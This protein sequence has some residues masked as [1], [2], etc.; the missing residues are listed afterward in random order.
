MALTPLLPTTTERGNNWARP[1]LLNAFRGAC[2]LRYH[3]HK[4]TKIFATAKRELLPI[5]RNLPYVNEVTAYSPPGVTRTSASAICF[6]IQTEAYQGEPRHL[7]WF[8]YLATQDGTTDKVLVKFTRQY[9]PEL[10][11]FCAERCHAPQLLGYNTIPGGWHVVV[12]EWIDHDDTNL[13]LYAPDHLP[14]WSKDLKSLVNGFHKEGWVHGD[15]RDANLIVSDEE[16]G[17]VML[18]DFDWGGNVGAGPVYY[19]TALVHEELKK[20]EHP[21]DLLI[22]QKHDA[23]VLT[24]TLNKLAG[25]ITQEITLA[26]RLCRAGKSLFALVSDPERRGS[27]GLIHNMYSSYHVHVALSLITFYNRIPVNSFALRRSVRL[28][29]RPLL[30]QVL[31]QRPSRGTA[32][33]VQ[34]TTRP[35]QAQPS[36]PT[37]GLFNGKPIPYCIYSMV[38]IL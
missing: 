32:V 36:T 23:D 28:C 5:Q 1:A 3:I 29:V 10:H 33:V 7:N 6:H 19:P 9:C 8:L 12:M 2:V 24:F 14:T 16:P 20:R 27:C 15:L 38:T 11:W 35:H 17:Q 21:G 18:V 30:Y 37:T 25:Q 31:S 34:G 22:T 4:D 26:Q 13:Q